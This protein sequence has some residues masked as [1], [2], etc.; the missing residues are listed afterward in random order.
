VTLTPPDADVSGG[1]SDALG[2]LVRLVVG[3]SVADW[4]LIGLALML[5]SW[6]WVRAAA[7]ARLGTIEITDFA[8]D[9]DALAPLAVK[10]QLQKV[11]G[12]RGLLPPSGVPS[13]SP[14]KSDIS[15]AVAAA[16]APQTNWLG[17]LIR[18]IPL[19]PASISF[20]LRATI[21]VDD[22]DQRGPL[23]LHYQLV[24]AGPHQNV[25][26]AAA[27]GTSW[28]STVEDA[29][30]DIYRQ[31]ARDAPAIY[32]RWAWWSSNR[33]LT[34][35][36]DGLTAEAQIAPDD[37]SDGAALREGLETAIR[38]YRA[39][40]QSDPG[41][42][43]A[44]LR[45]AN[46]LERQATECDASLDVEKG[47]AA[48]D[49]YVSIRCRHPGI[50]EAGYRASVLL[51]NIAQQLSPAPKS[52]A[53]DSAYARLDEIVTRLKP[54]AG[55]L[56][57][58]LPRRAFRR[59]K[60]RLGQIRDALRPNA[61]SLDGNP[62]LAN[63]KHAA[64]HESRRA[65]T[66]LWGPY[67]IMFEGRFRH[68][69]EP[70][71]R[72]RRELRQALRISRIC[73]AAR[74]AVL[75]NG[76][77]KVAENHYTRVLYPV[78]MIW[79]ARLVLGGLV[80]LS[81]GG[82]QTEYNVACFYSVLLEALSQH[83]PVIADEASG[84]SKAVLDVRDAIQK[85]RRHRVTRLAFK[86]LRRATAG[87]GPELKCRWVRHDDPDLESLRQFT[88]KA[89][90]LALAPICPEDVVAALHRAR[91]GGVGSVDGLR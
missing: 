50:F 71:G 64:L 9:A 2:W 62:V 32:P 56:P 44:A 12:E 8:A 30:K 23:G 5:L 73:L 84:V 91:G 45:C 79:R 51:S 1:V 13:G 40:M 67:T 14:T 86:H 55:D 26:L 47:L 49:A 82:W 76:E 58:T 42:M 89:F 15:N 53:P 33:A 70:T 59:V 24:C 74:R 16:P 61:F 41:N 83:P 66:R 48:L 63:A 35:F 11:L 88:P 19:P 68:R 22:T 28:P 10:A 39:A 80:S 81:S 54:H 75:G 31:I 90:E 36:G 27:R 4:I 37:L 25:T 72:E 52:W 46:C 43:L 17:A 7:F 29:A 3:F 69:F 20:H 34:H 18:V 77:G 57:A 78:Q 85:A 65:R 21:T 87:A 38:H 60:K 6:G